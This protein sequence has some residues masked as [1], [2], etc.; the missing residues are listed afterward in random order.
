M[1]ANEWWYTWM[2]GESRS[3]FLS[4]CLCVIHESRCSQVFQIH[5]SS[6]CHV[7]SVLGK[8]PR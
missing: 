3:I 6:N 8:R 1:T 2:S 5:L 7:P 4:C